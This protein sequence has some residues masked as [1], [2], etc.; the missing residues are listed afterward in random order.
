MHCGL[1]DSALCETHLGHFGLRASPNQVCIMTVGSRVLW[2]LFCANDGPD[3]SST[4]MLHVNLLVLRPL[5]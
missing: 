3:L 5:S 1:R 2:P 4:D